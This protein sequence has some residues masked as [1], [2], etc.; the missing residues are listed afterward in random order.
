MVREMLAL[1]H[2][3]LMEFEIVKQAEYVVSEHD[4]SGEFST[5]VEGFVG[6]PKS[7]KRLQVDAVETFLQEDGSIT[8]S[9]RL[10][11]S[12]SKVC[13]QV[14]TGLGQSQPTNALAHTFL[15][16][17]QRWNRRQKFS[18]SFIYPFQDCSYKLLDT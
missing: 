9:W 13:S 3:D 14:E 15:I 8:A 12:G 6:Q 10:Q 1:K 4:R 7:S 17:F 11:L 18:F 2:R 5:R 16:H